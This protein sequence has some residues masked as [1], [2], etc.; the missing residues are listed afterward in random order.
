MKN[1]LFFAVFLCAS[2]QTYAQNDS[3]QFIPESEALSGPSAPAAP[4]ENKPAPAK[5][6]ITS[7]NYI[8]LEQDLSQYYMYA[9]S[10]WDG[11][12]Y[13]G[14]NNCWIVKLPP[15]SAG[16][17]KAYIG[18]KLGR[19][20]TKPAPDKPWER[21]SVPGKIFIGLSQDGAF[22]SQQS[23][24]L[25]DSKDIP[26]EGLPKG[27]IKDTGSAQWFWAEIPPSAVSAEKPNYAAIWSSS[28]LFTDASASPIIAGAEDKDQKE[29]IVWINHSTKGIPPR[30]AKSAL[31]TPI[32]GLAPAIALKLIPKNTQKV[33]VEDFITQPSAK[34]VIVSFSV[35][36]KDTRAAW[37]EISY[38]RFDWQRVSS[39]SYQ[40]PYVFTLNKSL[41]PQYDAVFIRAAACDS[42]ENIGYSKDARLTA[43]MLK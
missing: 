9:N 11:N 25:V 30:D 23:Y 35:S 33:S 6:D 22:T 42:L 38:D 20:K 14:Y 21:V 10:G 15:V 31:E 41:F 2:A 18:A 1:I 19:A 43:A 4:T 8:S 24:F 29:T 37:V 28:E 26:L 32:T 40:P 16:F 36:G 13:V 39:L 12:W 3:I 5:Q 7:V 34:G 27:T 17:A